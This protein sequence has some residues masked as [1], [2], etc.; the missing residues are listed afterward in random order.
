[1]AP[2]RMLALLSALA[3]AV[4]VASGPASAQVT[5]ETILQKDVAGAA[6]NPLTGRYKDSVLLAQTAKAFDELTLPSGP[7]EGSTYSDSKK[8]KAVVTAQG[9]V[10]RSIYVAPAGRSS[11]EVLTNFVDALAA[12]GFEPV[13]RCSGDE[14]G[15]SFAVLKYKWD[16]PATKVI[17][18]NYDQLRRGMVD[19][20]FDQVVD[21]RYVLMKKAGAEGDTYVGL[22]AA[23]NRG[24]SFGDASRAFSDR[25][26]VLV[27]IVEPKAMDRRME[28][29]SAEQ[30]TGKMAA[31]GKAVFYGI[32]FDF[33][34]ADIKA[35]SEPQLAEMAKFLK[36][37][38]TLK[39]Y[40]TGHTDNKGTL[41]YNVTLSNKR[42]DAVAKALAKA[43][44]DPKRMTARGLGPLAPLASNRTEDGQAKNRR[45]ELVEQ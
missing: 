17:G 1:M 44:I 38:A 43:G 31:D 26:A 28:V 34:K 13:Y 18:A 36:E 10:T 30:I 3:A 4:P 32:Q 27:E 21:L 23:V 24:G 40:V 39:V 35:D 14:C 6:D 11:L 37:N 19:A 29:V 42:A 33:D 15:E 8:F 9:K 20:V 2:F 25:A 41:D 16:K 22:Y 45:V 12:K 5:Y 7:A